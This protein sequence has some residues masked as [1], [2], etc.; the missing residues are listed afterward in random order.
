M[1]DWEERVLAVLRAETSDLRELALIAGA[2]PTT[3]Y[4]DA[5]FRNCDLR[6][7]NLAGFDLTHAKMDGTLLDEEQLNDVLL[8]NSERG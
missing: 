5:N 2:D 3:F 4:R 6:G 7:E 1:S 8:N